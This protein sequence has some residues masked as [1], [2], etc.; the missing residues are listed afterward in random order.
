MTATVRFPSQRGG[1]GYSTSPRPSPGGG[2]YTNPGY[3]P[4]P[5]PANQNWRPPPSAA[6]N[7]Y[8]KPAT[9]NGFRVP[10]GGAAVRAAFAMSPVIA[11]G[12]QFYVDYSAWRAAAMS[13]RIHVPGGWIVDLDCGGTTRFCGRNN[14]VCN[15]LVS[16]AY[17]DATPAPLQYTP[18]TPWHVQG[19]AHYTSVYDRVK[20]HAYKPASVPDVAPESIPAIISPMVIPSP[21]NQP[22]VAPH[23]VPELDPFALPIRQPVPLP[24]ALPWGSPRPNTAPGRSPQESTSRGPRPRP[25]LRPNLNPRTLPGKVPVT[26]TNGPHDRSPPGPKEKE[27]KWSSGVAGSKPS[28]ILNAVTEA[29]D[30]VNALWDQ[31]PEHL[32]SKCAQNA[33]ICKARDIYNHGEHINMADALAAM[34]AENL[35]NRTQGNWQGYFNQSV[36]GGGLNPGAVNPTGRL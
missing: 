4:P 33:M 34:N 24:R 16:K 11:L 30:V 35:Q 18:G 7:N 13:P 5:R 3:R 1:T 6:N 27:K 21:F 26:F 23:Y 20:Y 8:P 28:K 17:V 32:R 36:T 25:R 9:P 19:V 31:I 29:N 15:N 22:F 10:Y 14:I 2:G 12:Y